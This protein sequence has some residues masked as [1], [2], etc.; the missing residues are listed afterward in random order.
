M[1]LLVHIC[2]GPCATYPVRFLREAGHDL[3]GFFYNPN[4]HPLAEH[5]LRLDSVRTLLERTGI[6]ATIEEEYDI[7]EF[8]RRAVFRENERCAGCYHLRLDRTAKTAREQGLDA[9]TTTLLVSPY[10]KHDLI[11]E[12]GRSVGL[13]H[14]VEFLYEDFRPGWSET[15]KMSKEMGLYRQKYCGCLYSEKERFRPGKTTQDDT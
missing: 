6:E 3:R 5:N 8:F 9:F 11:C 14:K 4:I 10:Q 2:C 7:E 1:K 15:R 12:I 13:E